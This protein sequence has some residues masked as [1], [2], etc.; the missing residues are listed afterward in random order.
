MVFHPKRRGSTWNVTVWETYHDW[1]KDKSPKRYAVDWPGTVEFVD[2]K[3]MSPKPN[4]HPIKDR[5]VLTLRLRPWWWIQINTIGHRWF[6]SGQLSKTAQHLLK[7]QVVTDLARNQASNQALYARPHK[8]YDRDGVA[9]IHWEIVD[10]LSDEKLG[11]GPHELDAW[12]AC[13]RHL[14][15]ECDDDPVRVWRAPNPWVT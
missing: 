8:K 6:K 4:N 5:K 9:N 1:V 10:P 15:I 12:R 3:A 11:A 14:G 13:C 7:T 2:T